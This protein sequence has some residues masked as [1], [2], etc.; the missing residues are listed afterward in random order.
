MTEIERCRSEIRAY[1]QEY[2]SL[3]PETQAEVRGVHYLGL[4]DWTLEE[5]LILSESTLPPSTFSP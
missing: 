2:A 4:R 3:P 1:Q 5:V